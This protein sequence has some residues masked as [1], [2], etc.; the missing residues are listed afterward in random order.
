MFTRA[1]TFIGVLWR[2]M[3][4]RLLCRT[5]LLPWGNIDLRLRATSCRLLILVWI[6]FPEVIS[7]TLWLID[8]SLFWV[9]SCSLGLQLL[10]FISLSSHIYLFTGWD[11]LFVSLWNLG[12]VIGRLNGSRCCFFYR[13]L[14][15]SGACTCWWVYFRWNL[16]WQLF[17]DTV[18]MRYGLS[19]RVLIATCLW[20]W[21][22]L[23]I[24]KLS[25]NYILSWVYIL[26][27][28]YSSI[29]FLFSNV[30]RS[31]ISLRQ[32][33]VHVNI[34]VEGRPV[35]AWWLSWSRQLLFHLH[36]SNRIVS[37][38]ICLR[39]QL[40]FP[41]SFSFSLLLSYSLCPTPW[42]LSPGLLIARF[43]IILLSFFPP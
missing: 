16:I 34:R 27:G 26:T 40:R 17:F 43:I 32:V 19:R 4:A 33:L 28:L 36:S 10:W 12:I 18:C 20:R 31:P 14:M 3:R 24:C 42:W 8:T 37:V 21:D 11:L 35:L 13:W 30:G 1:W 7:I 5:V 39:I 6:L 9:V 25:S 29:L 38:C 22:V 41:L 23:H 2:N 15:S